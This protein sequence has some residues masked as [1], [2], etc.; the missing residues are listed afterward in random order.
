MYSWDPGR[1][2][3]AELIPSLNGHVQVL[4]LVALDIV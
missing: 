2:F 1:R 4:F 3:R